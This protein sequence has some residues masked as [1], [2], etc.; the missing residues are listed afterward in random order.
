MT[1]QANKVIK[2][3]KLSTGPLPGVTSVNISRNSPTPFT[4]AATIEMKQNA[5]ALSSHSLTVIQQPF[6]RLDIPV[7]VST[8]VVE[9]KYQ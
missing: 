2:K 1:T 5:A 4:K 3:P 9:V 6:K 8:N 7:K